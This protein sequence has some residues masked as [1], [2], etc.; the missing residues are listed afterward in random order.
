MIVK[1]FAEYL[2]EPKRGYY[3]SNF[4]NSFITVAGAWSS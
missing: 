1:R 3:L 4:F 2:Y